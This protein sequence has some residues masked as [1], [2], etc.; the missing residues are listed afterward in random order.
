[1]HGSN[2][3]EIRVPGSDWTTKA[4]TIILFYNF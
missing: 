1:M 4:D 3:V 2:K